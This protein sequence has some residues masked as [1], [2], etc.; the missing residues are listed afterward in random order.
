[1]SGTEYAIGLL[2]TECA[3][4]AYGWYERAEPSVAVKGR[5]TVSLKRETEGVA[6]RCRLIGPGPLLMSC[7]AG[8]KLAWSKVCLCAGAD[9]EM[10]SLTCGYDDAPIC[11]EGM[12]TVLNAGL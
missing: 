11:G 12:L 1:M 5:R 3:D 6:L 4:V 10:Y 7:G 8:Y 9:I 2:S